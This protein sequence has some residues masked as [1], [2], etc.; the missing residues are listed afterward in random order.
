MAI[1]NHERVGNALEQFNG[2]LQSPVGLAE[3]AGYFKRPRGRMASHPPCRS[4]SNEARGGN[5]QRQF[6]KT[7]VPEGAGLP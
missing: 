6:R 7:T 4:C 3:E 1:T 2:G 5:C